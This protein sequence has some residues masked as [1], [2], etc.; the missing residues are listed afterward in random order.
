MEDEDVATFEFLYGFVEKAIDL[1]DD[2][3]ELRHDRRMNITHY[4]NKFEG[5]KSLAFETLRRL[6]DGYEVT[7]RRQG[8]FPHEDDISFAVWR[9]LRPM[10]HIFTNSIDK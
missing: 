4:L 9:V 7:V 6:M 10:T 3:L 2:R 8:L 1:S 5:T